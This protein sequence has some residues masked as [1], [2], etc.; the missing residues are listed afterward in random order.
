MTEIAVYTFGTNHWPTPDPSPFCTK[1]LGY[2]QLADIP[3]EHHSGMQYIR[4]APK[5]KMPYIKS[6]SELLGDSSLIINWLKRQF[7]DPLNEGLSVE[8]RALTH[9]IGKMLEENTYWVIVHSRWIDE[10]NWREHTYPTFFGKLNPLLRAI[11]PSVLRRGVRKQMQAQ[12]VGRHTAE[13]IYQIGIKDMNVLADLLGA[14]DFFFGDGPREIDLYAY[15]TLSGIV[16]VPH[17]TPLREFVA[18][19]EALAGFHA[20]MN[21]RL[22]Q[23]R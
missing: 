12:G 2:L 4:Q 22:M 18:N 9:A 13:E 17:Q 7:G 14:Q 1:L 3:F 21:Q 16:G 19:H 11:F 20:R 6:D 23:A 15:A 5:G 8:Q 10:D